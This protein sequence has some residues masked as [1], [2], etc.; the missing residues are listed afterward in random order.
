M[1]WK[2]QP[3]KDYETVVNLIAGTKTEKGLT[4]TGQLD[5]QIYKKGIR[6]TKEQM[7]E[8]NLKKQK[9]QGEWNYSIKKQK[10]SV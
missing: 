8:I 6:I 4:V 5:K 10:R 2:G 9:F 3:L 1:N 7:Q